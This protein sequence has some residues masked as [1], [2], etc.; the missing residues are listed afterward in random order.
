MRNSRYGKCTER[1]LNVPEKVI[2]SKDAAVNAFIN[3]AGFLRLSHEQLIE[4]WSPDTPPLTIVFSSLGRSLSRH[5]STL[6][7][8]VLRDICKTMEELLNRGDD[9]VK[10]A[11][12]TGMLEAMLGESSAGRCDMLTFLPFLG[13]QTKSFCRSWDEFTGNQTPGLF[14]A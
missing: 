6:S 11:V 14:D 4:E 10:N 8:K 2:Y 5:S 3:T 1:G 12:A 7:K 13:N 9:S